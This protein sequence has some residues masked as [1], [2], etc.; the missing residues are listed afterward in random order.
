MVRALEAEFAVSYPELGVILNVFSRT[1]PAMTWDDFTAF[2]ELALE[3]QRESLRNW[4]ASRER[5][6]R[7]FAAS[8]YDIGFIG[9][10]RQGMN[11]IAYRD[12]R[13]FDE[14]WAACAPNPRVYIHPAFYALLG[15]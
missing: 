11:S 6:P 14:T 7:W 3:D 9:L 2:A 15:I 13:S 5:N 1:E 4:A 12:G 10:S 8:L